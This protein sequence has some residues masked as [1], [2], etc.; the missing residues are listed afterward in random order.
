MNEVKNYNIQHEKALFEIDTIKDRIKYFEVKI[1]ELTKLYNNLNTTIV[2]IEL[3]FAEIK[4]DLDRMMQQKETSKRDVKS[5]ILY[6][7]ISN[8]LG[9]ITGII[10]GKLVGGNS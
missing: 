7:V 2:K 6:P 3:M 9:I 5:G 4:N 10:I 8:V 1:E